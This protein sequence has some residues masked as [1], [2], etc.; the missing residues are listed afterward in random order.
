LLTVMEMVVCDLLGAASTPVPA[1]VLAELTEMQAKLKSPAVLTPLAK[2]V[3]LEEAVY[4]SGRKNNYYADRLGMDVLTDTTERSPTFCTPSFRKFND[5]TA[6]ESW[7]FLF[8]P[9]A[10]T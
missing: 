8:L 5:P 10:E 1:S 2:L 6:A 4:R 3:A 9:C 7:A